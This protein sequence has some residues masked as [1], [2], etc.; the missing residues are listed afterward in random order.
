MHTPHQVIG[1][2]IHE[3][4][5]NL[6]KKEGV[7]DVVTNDLNRVLSQGDI[8]F[9]CLYP[10]E[11][12]AFIR[13]HYREFKDGAIITDCAGLKEEI[14]DFF[15]KMDLNDKSLEFIGGHPMAGS[16][17]KG[18]IHANAGLFEE[19]SFIIT[20]HERNDELKIHRLTELLKEIKFAE[21][22]RMS[23]KEHDELVAYTSHLPH[24][25][26]NAL[27]V[28]KP[29]MVTRALEGGSFKDVTRVGHMNTQL[30]QEL[31]LS[32]QE[33]VLK[34]LNEFDLQ[35]TAVKDAIKTMN[36]ASLIALFEG[37]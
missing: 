17:K 13:E 22:T 16:E 11:T 34:Y 15:G 9:I 32:N 35:M 10:K 31:I 18:Y 1:F 29:M 37:Q 3:E 30:W 2:D 23:A 21:V 8:V 36:G 25:I 24:I 5:L 7:I 6:A 14:T 28:K 20:P 27:L 33:N 4:T 12:I 26:A 19:A